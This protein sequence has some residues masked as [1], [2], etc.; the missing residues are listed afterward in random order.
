MSGAEHFFRGRPY[1]EASAPGRVNLLGE[2]TDYNDGYVLPVATPMRTSVAPA[3]RPLAG[4][5]R[6]VYGCVK[7]IEQ[8]GVAV[9][10][11][12]AGGHCG[13]MD[14]MA[15]S[16]C[17]ERHMPFLDTRT[18]AGSRYYERGTECGTAARALGVAALR[19]VANMARV[20]RGD[21]PF[22]FRVRHVV[23]ESRRVLTD[24]Y[25]NIRNNPRGPHG[26]LPIPAPK[27]P[28]GA[29]S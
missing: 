9:P 16:L 28:G 21:P 11:L 5:G 20:E 24:A 6:Y 15:A 4:F 22:R 17:D 13:I 14:Q 19:D 23:G 3:A 29:L 12:D 8:Q 26:R 25:N 18:L 1:T 27:Q 7:L 2:H 10:P